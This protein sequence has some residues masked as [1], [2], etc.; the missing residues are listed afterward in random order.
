ME[1][2]YNKLL[3]GVPDIKRSFQWSEVACYKVVLLHKVH[4]SFWGMSETNS[5]LLTNSELYFEYHIWKKARQI[6]VLVSQNLF[7]KCEIWLKSHVFVNTFISHYRTSWPFT[8]KFTRVILWQISSIN[9]V[10]IN[11]FRKSYANWGFYSINVAS[12]WNNG[13]LLLYL[14]SVHLSEALHTSVMLYFLLGI[15]YIEQCIYI[16]CECKDTKGNICLV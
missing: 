11:K 14:T 15:I 12:S 2:H 6:H 8:L 1:P 3:W 10:C 4:S 9:E 16:V 13:S 5:D 7:W